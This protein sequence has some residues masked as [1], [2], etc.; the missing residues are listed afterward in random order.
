MYDLDSFVRER[1]SGSDNRFRLDFTRRFEPHIS[2][3]TE[4]TIQLLVVESPVSSFALE[5]QKH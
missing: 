1:E 5:T 3:C 2:C 4:G